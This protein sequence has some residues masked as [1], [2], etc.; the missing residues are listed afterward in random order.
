MAGCRQGPSEENHQCLPPPRDRAWAA[1]LRGEA[2]VV[3]G[4]RLGLEMPVSH[5]DRLIVLQDLS[6][7]LSV[8]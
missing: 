5:G 4:T 3:V 6:I 7:G 2:Q 8:P 1:A